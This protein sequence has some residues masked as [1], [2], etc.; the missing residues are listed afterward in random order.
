MR[1]FFCLIMCALLLLPMAVIT[2]GDGP[3]LEIRPAEEAQEYVPIILKAGQFDPKYDRGLTG[4]T[5]PGNN[6]FKLIQFLGPAENFWKA[7]VQAMGVKLYGY[8][9]ENAFIADVPENIVKDVEA[10]PYVRAVVPFEPGYKFNPEDCSETVRYVVWVMGDKDITRMALNDMGIQTSPSNPGEHHLE[11]TATPEQVEQIAFIPQVEW[12]EPVMEAEV[13]N[14]ISKE[15]LGTEWVWDNLGFDGSGET[16]TVA[17]TG[18]DTGV[19][20]HLVADDI[21]RDFDNRVTFWQPT[22]TTQADT[23]GHGTHV[24]GSVLGDGSRSSGNII[25]M[26][27]GADLYVQD[28]ALDT[29]ALL[30]PLNLSI[31]FQD[32]YDNGSRIH[33]NSWTTPTAN[34]GSYTSYSRYVDEFVWQH[35]NM[36]ILFAVGNYGT[37]ANNDGVSDTNTSK[38]PS[39]AKNCIAVGGSEN[40]RAGF[41]AT[42]GIQGWGFNTA[43]IQNDI[44]ADN[45]SGMW[46]RSARGPTDDGRI[47][48]DV[49]APATYVLSAKSSL[50]PVSS[51]GGYDT[52][53]HYMGGTSMATPLVAGTAALVR[54]FYNTNYSHDA[55]GALVKATIINGAEDM[56]PGQYGAGATADVPGWPDISQGWGRVNAADSINSSTKDNFLYVDHKI[57][58]NH[59]GTWET[60]EVVHS[61]S[62]PLRIT[63]TW[64]DF[65]ATLAAGKDLVN[66]LDLT[67]TG[68]TGTVYWGN[69]FTTPF[70]T[71]RD[72]TN[73]VECV[74]IDTPLVGSYTIN[75][76]G[77]NVV[78]GPQPFAI[79]MSGPIS[80]SKGQVF[81]NKDSYVARSVPQIELLDGD[82][83]SD[84]TAQVRVT[85]TLDS[86]AGGLLV[87]LNEVP[88]NSG[89]FVGSVKLSGST[90][91]AGEVQVAFGGT[92]TVNYT[93]ASP[94]GSRLD[95]ASIAYMPEIYNVSH[96]AYTILTAGDL[97][98]V[99][100][101]GEVGYLATFSLQGLGVCQNLT[102][103]DDGLH[104]DE[105]PGDGVYGEIWTVPP[106]VYGTFDY[107]GF[108]RS[109]GEDP[110][111]MVHPEPV[112]INTSLPHAPKGLV[113][114]VP[115][116]GD[117]LD[118]SWNANAEPDVTSY[119][120]FRNATSDPNG[121]YVEVGSSGGLTFKD[122]GLI[123]GVEYFYKLKAVN[124]WSNVSGFS[125]YS[126]GIPWDTLGP[127]I[128]ILEPEP[129]DPIGG[130]FQLEFL[131]DT[132]TEKVQFE[133][134]NDTNQNGI[135]DDGNTW[136]RITTLTTITGV[137]YWDTTAAGQG[138]DNQPSVL[139]KAY[140]WDEKPNLG[141]DTI[142]KVEVDNVP[143]NAPSLLDNLPSITNKTSLPLSG[144]SEPNG[145]VRTVV[146]SVLQ[147]T[148]Y[149]VNGA[150]NFSASA[151]FTTEGL[152]EVHMI[153][154][155]AAMNG[156]SPP[157]NI[158]TT[159]T[160]FTK[161]VADT[162]GANVT[163]VGTEFTLDGSNSFDPGA[164]VGFEALANHT[165]SFFESGSLVELY[166]EVQTYSFIEIKTYNV[167][168]KVADQAGNRNST[169]IYIDV[170]DTE[171]P[172][173][174]AGKNVT[175]NEDQVVHF[176]GTGTTDNDP[177]LYMDGIFKW[178]FVD[179]KSRTLNGPSPTYE[180][181]TPGN[182]TITLTVTDPSGNSAS[183]SLWVKVND[184]T[185]PLVEAGSDVNTTKGQWVELNASGTTD[186]DPIYPVGSTF[187]W[188]LTY[189]GNVTV[190][191]GPVASFQ[192]NILGNYMVT[193]NVTDASGNKGFDTLMV[194]VIGDTQAPFVVSTYPT[195]D[196]VHRD[197][198]ED[199][200]IWV[201]FNE[202]LDPVF[203]EEGSLM[204]RDSSTGIQV[205]GTT[206]YIDVDKKILFSP[207]SDLQPETRY[208][209]I[210]LYT[211]T[212]LAGNKMGAN[213]TFSFWTTDHPRVVSSTPAPG[214]V[215]IDHNIATI[216]AV[217]TEPIFSDD[218]SS[219]M[220]V[221]T[222]GE[223]V[224]GTVSISGSTLVFLPKASL[225]QNTT[226]VVEILP[227]VEDVMGNK[228]KAPYTW[229]FKTKAPPY[230]PPEPPTDDDDDD[231]DDD[232]DG[233]L[234]FILNNL[235][236]FLIPLIVF[237]LIIIIAVILLIVIMRRRPTEVEPMGDDDYLECPEC[238]L[239][240]YPDEDECPECGAYID[241][242]DDEYDD[243]W[244]DEDG[245][246]E[247]D[248]KGDFDD[249]FD[250]PPPRGSSR[251]SRGSRDRYDDDWNDDDWEDDYHH[252]E[253]N[254]DD[255]DYP[256]YEDD[257]EPKPKRSSGRRYDEYDDDYDDYGYDYDDDF[258]ESQYRDK[259]GS[260]DPYGDH[261]DDYDEEYEDDD[262]DD[263]YEDDD[264]DDDDW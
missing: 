54:E 121:T 82:L 75:V 119:R 99:N 106:G 105:L 233:F 64:S 20:N 231:D 159:V 249:D 95:T 12:I 4:L 40:Y 66:D 182:F 248:D 210:A 5:D 217:F 56:K 111:W 216:T 191:N 256:D 37:D 76:R 100:L 49:V 134:Y 63:L 236:W 259:R 244:D 19:D 43:P 3:V 195:W 35:P 74:L 129:D 65:P 257:W 241:D 218:P 36:T 2:T 147:P 136:V 9:P 246:Y 38:P 151:N 239:E 214:S 177:D 253:E 117:S 48:P 27:P 140:G 198:P 224:P 207:D 261:W 225:K 114:T 153:S 173:A 123:D 247:D 187:K 158:V 83:Q 166:G 220:K 186:N 102:L 205:K 78:R 169:I 188:T 94:S 88:S 131:S 185:S 208:D 162:D 156:P 149:S 91:G 194:R 242:Y 113:V 228:M 96:D 84:G 50:A 13:Q 1:G 128:D 132:D 204:V 125:R 238:G 184:I 7:D 167:T 138:P 57:G 245:G 135:E 115:P 51:W 21:H 178:T 58:L 212:D 24:A 227:E 213:E 161:P 133:Y 93:D 196:K 206:S 179:G 33:T 72:R 6:Q 18:L 251:G 30:A 145:F 222:G 28:I 130:T 211:I 14:S 85:S 264:F 79:A 97:L 81:F 203:A 255:D 174:D 189:D 61:S 262:Y 223:N 45:T 175:I 260:P 146:N 209:V 127:T 86:P 152:Q 181:K 67:V 197:I 170:I 229:D 55:S 77:F 148:L 87:T 139:L 124:S 47:K 226:Y 163:E 90:P 53:Y 150:G 190:L 101:T 141:G 202:Y 103:Y 32:A 68:P 215:D 34:D 154:F 104:D 168:L 29:G 42:Y 120:V 137:G 31:L 60:T 116:E 122:N 26:A 252:G 263:D 201:V 17:D 108:L 59:A 237:V 143:P 157:S 155:D 15:I 230:V 199:I 89:R 71:A 142:I 258:G 232:E 23:E 69:D 8:I 200:D 234:D 126:S 180:F 118:L 109:P 165:W 107:F 44:M 80:P 243:D 11:I 192:F 112:E 160:D 171:L 172:V 92:L 70:N 183:D 250:P 164:Y 52:Y 235:F 16:V 39:T 221:S 46:A 22:G 193:L 25:G 73:N 176:D 62:D 144:S 254:F 98:A 219:A 10:H 240:L 41:G 110:N